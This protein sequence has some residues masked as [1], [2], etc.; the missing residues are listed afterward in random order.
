MAS[1][2]GSCVA[3]SNAAGG[4]PDVKETEVL[5]KTTMGDIRIKLYNET[6]EHRQNFINLVESNSYDSVLF[7]RVI[8][9]FMIQGGDPE[10]KGAAKGEHLGSGQVGNTLPA[11]ILFPQYYHKRGAVCA[12][13]LADQ[14]N[15]DRRS[16]GSQ[17]YIVTGKK[18]QEDE[19]RNMARQLQQQQGQALFDNLCQEHRDEIIR[20][21]REDDDEGLMHLQDKLNQ[22]LDSIMQQR[23]VFKFTSEQMK[24]YSTIGG[25]PQLDGQYTVF[26]EVVEGMDV[27]DKIQK[28]H[29]DNS[30]RPT[31]D[32]MIISTSIIR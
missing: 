19:L 9:N 6:A 2:L 1:I 14:V 10:S 31:D 11:E 8:R 12:A 30:D 21:Q 16:S 3:K 5:I 17:F 24:T 20:M 18:Y 25:T 15:P 27:V 28:V 7:H 23:G 32:V 29:T 4:N 22:Q 13:R 26:G